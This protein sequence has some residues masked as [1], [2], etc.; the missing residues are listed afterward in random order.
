MMD[1][2]TIDL[3]NQD[4][5]MLAAGRA[6]FSAFL[7]THFLNLPDEPFV[8]QL[9]SDGYRQVLESLLAGEDDLHPD[10]AEGA[11]L[12]HAYLSANREMGPAALSQALGVDRTRL[13]RG[14]SPTYSPPPPYEAVWSAELGEPAGLL[15]RIA[16]IYH[17]SGLDQAPGVNERLDYIGIELAYMEYLA[18][19]EAGAR[20]AGDEGHA[21]DLLEEQRSFF[22]E[23]LTPWVPR[24]VE[25]ALEFAHTDFYRGHLLM[26]RGYV[27]EQ[28][29]ILG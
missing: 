27:L 8:E 24:F 5:Q 3:S 26:L 23:H 29:A 18:Q 15:Q 11:R 7:S 20:E 19:E 22:R 16:A 6:S 2:A 9:R 1:E 28:K 21:A 25:K 17:Q 12:M 10:I 4:L 13:Y 14:I